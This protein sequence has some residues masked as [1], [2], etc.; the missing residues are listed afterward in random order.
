MRTEP[1]LP[2]FTQRRT[3]HARRTHRTTFRSFLCRHADAILL[4]W[5]CLLIAGLVILALA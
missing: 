3:R 4:L 2:T 1:S 5:S